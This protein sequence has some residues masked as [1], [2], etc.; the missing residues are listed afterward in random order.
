MKNDNPDAGLEI[1]QL[2]SKHADSIARIVDDASRES[3]KSCRE[4]IAYRERWGIDEQEYDQTVSVEELNVQD[5]IAIKNCQAML[6]FAKLLDS[7]YIKTST[8]AMIDAI[9]ARRG[10][11]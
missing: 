10:E 3:I 7:A 6:R 2:L 8:A 11:A 5:E 4:R 9:R 1:L